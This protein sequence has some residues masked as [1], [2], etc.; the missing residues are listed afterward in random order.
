MAEEKT[1]VGTILIVDDE[2][3]IRDL[4][5]DHFHAKG[6]RIL[7]AEDGPKALEAAR[8]E[9]LDAMIIDIRM[10]GMDGIQLIEEVRKFNEDVPIVLMT[11]YPS[12]D[13][14]VRALRK[15]VYDYVVKPFQV[16]HLELI[17]ARAVN[18]HRL[19]RLNQDLQR[20]LE[21]AHQELARVKARR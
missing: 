8:A 9:S 2:L 12:F 6:Y 10:P 5:Y 3:L 19:A 4:L 14:A 21:E 20:Q 15:R 18:E 7:T 1:A 16:P 11:G 13:S 17:V